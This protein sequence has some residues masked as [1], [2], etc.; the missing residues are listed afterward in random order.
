MKEKGRDE[1][2]FQV[3]VL[4]PGDWILSTLIENVLNE[5]GLVNKI[6]RL[7]WLC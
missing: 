1:N 3:K 4:N 5:E 7:V 2:F 6:K